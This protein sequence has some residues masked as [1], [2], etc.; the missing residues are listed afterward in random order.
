MY[1]FQTPPVLRRNLLIALLVVFIAISF[2]A[3]GKLLDAEPLDKEAH[4]RIEPEF[5]IKDNYTNDNMVLPLRGTAE[6]N[7]FYNSA[8][9]DSAMSLAQIKDAIN[10][11]GEA[12]RAQEFGDR[13]LILRERADGSAFCTMLYAQKQKN[14][15]SPT[16]GRTRYHLFALEA[17][18]ILQDV[19]ANN[20][21]YE[22]KEYMLFPWH[23]L[24]NDI[25][26]R[27][28][29]A[30]EPLSGDVYYKTRYECKG[31]MDFYQATGFYQLT[32]TENGFT[33]YSETFYDEES[34]SEL[35]REIHFRFIELDGERL[36]R[37]T[38][39]EKSSR[40]RG[41]ERK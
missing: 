11:M 13:L 25:L 22:P 12:Y 28:F 40:L 23:L 27:D 8:Q 10:G 15:P 2:T 9:L 1:F 41:G 37:M 4:Y 31:F 35:P 30:A 26:E 6:Y 16:G 21:L 7:L 24:E 5:W 19:P 17:S 14:I 32:P 39:G 34:D 29:F 33:A 20:A 36:F 18:L 38:V 3:Q